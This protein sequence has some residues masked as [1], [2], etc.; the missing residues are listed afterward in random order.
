[1]RIAV[2]TITYRLLGS[3]LSFA[4]VY[5]YTWDLTAAVALGGA[6]LVAKSMLYFWHELIWDIYS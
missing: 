3:L 5:I 4:L 2:K 6:D 1:M